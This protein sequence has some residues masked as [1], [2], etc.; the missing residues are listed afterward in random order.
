MPSKGKVL[1][2]GG[3]ELPDKN[4][5]AQRVIG[6]AKGLQLLGYEVVFLNSLKNCQGVP[7]TK[8]LYFG[9]ECIEYQRENIFDYLVGAKNVLKFIGHV[10]PDIVIAY[11]YP[12]IA[13]ERIMRYCHR[14]E[15]LVYADATEWYQAC[16]GNI[17]YNLIKN[18]DTVLRMKIVHKRLDGIIAISRYLF[19]YYKKE[20]KTVLIPPTIDLA[21]VKWQAVSQ[22]ERLSNVAFVYAGSPSAQKERLDVV[23]SAVENLPAA[24]NVQL[25]VVG[26]T[27]DQFVAIYGY[28][29]NL[30]VRTRFW[31]RV[32]HRQAIDI[33]KKSDWSIILRDN[34]KVVEAG[35]PTKLVES[36]SCGTPV[37]VNKF[38]NISDYLDKDNSII[39][40]SWQD[41]DKA[42][43]CA[44]DRRSEMVERD[45]FDYR[46]YVYA[47]AELVANKY[48]VGE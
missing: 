35:F 36:I 20:V 39:I 1:Y 30:T 27:K 22:K 5:A 46:R 12:A 45:L 13:L 15:M 21:D 7:K 44:I 2:I 48:N 28:K 37:I 6:I 32:L 43:L 26:V 38:S 23:V 17:F 41:I 16:G 3:F 47:L 11:N 24:Y 25:H 18:I 9:F 34:N 40:E 42:L 10:Q 8:K 14:H 33:V 4:A 19:D 31:G 29:H